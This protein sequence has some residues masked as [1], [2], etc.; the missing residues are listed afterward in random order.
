MNSFRSKRLSSLFARRVAALL[1]IGAASLGYAGSALAQSCPIGSYC[2]YAPPILSA[3]AVAPDGYSTDIVLSSPAGTITGSIAVNG[4]APQPFS[5]TSGTPVNI[6]MGPTDNKISGFLVAEERGAFIVATSSDLVVDQRLTAAYWQSS[7]TVK[8]N[9]IGL[10]TRFRA[11]SYSLNDDS[12]DGTGYDFISVY[13]PAA[14]TVTVEA[15]PGA[16]A[17]FWNDGIAG[18]THSFMLQAGQTYMLRSVPGADIDGALITSDQPVSVAI[19]GRGWHPA[20]CGD[21]GMD[22]LIPTSLLGTQY[23]VDDYPASAAEIVR[24]VA[25]TDGTTVSVD[26]VVVATLNQGEF[27]Q[28]AVSGVTFIETSQPAY[29]FQNAGEYICE[30]DVAM[31]PPISFA[32]MSIDISFNV[33]GNGTANIIIPT[34]AAG[35]ILLDGAPPAGSS[36]VTVPTHPEWSRVRFP[37]T[38]GNHS[39][40]AQ[41]DFQLGMVSAVGDGSSG[42]FAYFNPYRLPG[43]GDGMVGASEG[44]DD[45]NITDGDGCSSTCQIEPGYQCMS[46]PSMCSVI[47]TDGDGIG[48]LIEAA[49]GYD[50]LNADADG[51]GVL[52]PADLD[53]DNDGIPNQIECNS[54]S[55]SLANGS[56]E[57][58]Q[59]PLGTA[60]I[61]NKMNIPGWDTTAADNN[62]E[63]WSSGFNGV[64]SADGIQFAELNANVESTLFQDVATT[65]GQAYFYRFFHRGRLGDDTMAFLV[66]D[67]AG[68]LVK[69]KQVTTGTAA[70]QLVTGVYTVPAGQTTSRFAFESISSTGGAAIGNFL[71]GIVFTPGCTVDTDMDGTFDFRDTDSDNDT[72]P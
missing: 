21:D 39:I 18:L 5:V 11:G 38:G 2:Y 65:P 57:V 24:V 15:P 29:V 14:A 69:Q 42:L 43:C 61:T 23:V 8:S 41:S 60:Q 67:P 32:P 46:E 55:L 6:P 40:S 36:V 31:I 22:H 66:G 72:Y 17:P 25:D 20:G 52:D 51:D 9:V 27:Y 68:P 34:V 62:M 12:G 64:P 1:A 10:G 49:I 30:F 7:S 19:G 33:I 35:T 56:F 28:P 37:V 58:P 53:L 63:I 50:P 70:W 3:P 59:I 44:C 13:A 45:A 48:D 26:G 71:D 54:A 16:A 4:G 47:D